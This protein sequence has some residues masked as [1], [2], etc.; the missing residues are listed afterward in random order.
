VDNDWA[1]RLVECPYCHDTVTAPGMSA[2]AAPQARPVGQPHAW[3]TA[4]AGPMPAPPA[5]RSNGVAVVALL[6]AIASL[7]LGVAMGFY[8]FHVLT[9]ILGTSPT[10]EQVQKT[11]QDAFQSQQP[12]AIRLGLGFLAAMALWLAGVVCAVVGMCRNAPR[13]LAIAALVV[14]FMPVLMFALQR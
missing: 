9:P 13:G 10:Q 3:E 1:H 5:P 2:L 4:E 6:L 14:L 12:W 11:I 7:S 8:A